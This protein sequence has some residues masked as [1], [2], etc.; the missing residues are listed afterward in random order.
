MADDAPYKLTEM[1]TY[2]A[3]VRHVVKGAL[4]HRVNGLA[5]EVAFFALFA[6]PPSLLALFAAIGF[7][8]EYVGPEAT[9][10][11]RE[12][13]L[14][15]AERFLTSDTVKTVIAPTIDELLKGGR[16]D[17][18]S[19][20]VL[21]AL[22]STSRAADTLL[23]ALHIVYAI[24][25]R[26]S[27]WKRRGLAF[28]YTLVAVLWGAVL[29]PLLVMGPDLGRALTRPFGLESTVDLVWGVLYW[30]VLLTG[31]L[32]TLTA[33]YH[34]A[35]PWR[36]PFLRDLPGSIFAMVLWVVGTWALRAYGRWV[37]DSSPIYGSLA[38]PMIVLVWLY[39][40][41]FGVLMGAE[42][43][44]AVETLWPTITRKEKKQVL[45]KAVEELRA[46]GDDVDPVSVTGPQR[47]RT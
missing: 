40:T 8:S 43:N 9:G 19:I 20:G 28:L 41:G 33:V 32:V 26:L 7:V 15:N 42:L 6:L 5:A 27:I 25:E 11:V 12:E 14:I 45:K 46:A 44:A 13:L 10:R 37:V 1:R 35:L 22:W 39:F 38:S 21:F 4:D 47:P 3:I 18:L 31:V 29:L 17:L 24:D 30:P 36:T 16:A 2:S 34:F 23:A